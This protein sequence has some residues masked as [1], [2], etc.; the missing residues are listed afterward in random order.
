VAA[1]HTIE[2]PDEIP[3]PERPDL[4]QAVASSPNRFVRESRR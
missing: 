3:D 2:Y 1:P 4:A